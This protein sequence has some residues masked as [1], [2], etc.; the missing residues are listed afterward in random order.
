[1]IPLV[2]SHPHLY[3]KLANIH[4]IDKVGDETFS[5]CHAIVNMNEDDVILENRVDFE[6]TF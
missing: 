4:E 2:T 5:L 6:E 1:M 3:H